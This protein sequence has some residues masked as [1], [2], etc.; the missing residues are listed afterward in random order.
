M[1]QLVHDL[2][3]PEDALIAH[4]CDN[5]AC[6]N[7]EHLFL[8]TPKDNS[9][10]MVRKQRG[11]RGLRHGS[12]TH[13]E[14]FRRGATVGTAKLTEAAVLEIRARRAEGEYEYVLAEHFG[15]SQ[16]NIHM[17]VTRQTWAHI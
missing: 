12:K 13:P 6:V 4:T 7:P 9:A 17:I 5:P 15:V 8:A 10:D 14:R 1:F 2:V 3:L 11:A 16:S